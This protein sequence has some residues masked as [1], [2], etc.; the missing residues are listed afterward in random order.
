MVPCHSCHIYGTCKR[1]GGAG[2]EQILKS[3]HVRRAVTKAHFLGGHVVPVQP[4][5]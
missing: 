2:E 4:M 3:S 5:V 1:R